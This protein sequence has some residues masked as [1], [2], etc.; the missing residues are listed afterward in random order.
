MK[1]NKYEIIL[2]ITGIIIFTI[3]LF[4]SN[5][6]LSNTSSNKNT[7][8]NTIRLNNTQLNT[9]N[10]INNHV[11]ENDSMCPPNSN[12]IKK[13]VLDCIQKLNK[14]EEKNGQIFPTKYNYL[15]QDAYC[16]GSKTN[17]YYPLTDQ[18]TCLDCI[19]DDS[20]HCPFICQGGRG[21]GVI[22]SNVRNIN[23]GG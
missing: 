5:N 3:T 18:K 11:A 8:N 21:G 10:D 12:T 6:T 23:I 13:D 19:I 9:L 20:K 4:I 15:I 16:C 1:I 14:Y 7:S 17:K 2:L 22:D